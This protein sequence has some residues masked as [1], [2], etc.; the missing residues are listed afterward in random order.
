[1]S[2]RGR[3]KRQR[4]QKRQEKTMSEEEILRLIGGDPIAL[5]ELGYYEYLDAAINPPG[6]LEFPRIKD[7]DIIV[8]DDEEP[9]F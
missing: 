4:W 2:K 3:Q 7:Q 8:R 1:M 5:L 9:P 6:A